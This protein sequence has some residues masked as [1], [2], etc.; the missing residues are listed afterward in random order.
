MLND[1]GFCIWPEI[2][3]LINLGLSPESI[4]LGIIVGSYS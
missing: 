3:T 4:E 1:P 2:D